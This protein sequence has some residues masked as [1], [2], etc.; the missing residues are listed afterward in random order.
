MGLFKVTREQV[1]L[2]REVALS[3]FVQRVESELRAG[4]LTG[5]RVREVSRETLRRQ[6]RNA[7]ERGRKAG[8]ETEME[9]LLYI[10]AETLLGVGFQNDR[11]QLPAAVVMRSRAL[12][13]REKAQALFHFARIMTEA[14]DCGSGPSEGS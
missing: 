6:I 1:A 3:D 4:D 14:R 12:P 2:F 11:R 9:L 7:M 8:F 13:A 10:K 5:G